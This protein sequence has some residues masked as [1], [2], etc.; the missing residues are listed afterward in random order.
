M[1]TI[2]PNYQKKATTYQKKATGMMH[3]G[4]FGGESTSE[5]F[6][7]I[8]FD[9]FI[10]TSSHY[11]SNLLVSS[12]ADISTNKEYN[13]RHLCSLFD[14]SCE[15]AITNILRRDL[16]REASF[17]VTLVDCHF[18]KW[19][20]NWHSHP[21]GYDIFMSPELLSPT[22]KGFASVNEE[23]L[24]LALHAA[25]RGLYDIDL[26]T[27][28]VFITSEYA[29]MLGYE[30]F[31]FVE[32]RDAWV[33]RLH[34]DD[35]ASTKKA[36][37]EY[38]SGKRASYNVEFRQKRK[39]GTYIWIESTAK[40]VGFSPEGRPT[41]LIGMHSDIHE[42]KIAQLQ[43]AESERLLSSFI[44][45]VPVALFRGEVGGNW[46]Y[47]S[48]RWGEFTGRSIADA[49]DF[50]W[51][52]AIHHEDKDAL[53]LQWIRWA[54][55]LGDSF[56]QAEARF[57]TPLHNER[58]FLIQAFREVDTANQLN[59]FFGT[60]TDTTKLK[61]AEEIAKDALT[62]L[63]FHVEN[64]P[65]AVIEWDSQFSIRRW[66]RAAEKVFG[67]T[68]NEMIGKNI[69]EIDL[70]HP[71]D[72]SQVNEIYTALMEAQESHNISFNRNVRKD[73]SVAYAEWYNSAL[74]NSS[75]KLDSSLSI[76]LDVTER[77]ELEKHRQ[78]MLDRER[79][80]REEA[81]K[82]NRLKDE[83]LAVLSHELRTPLNPILGWVRLLRSGECTEGRVP[84]ALAIIEKNTL[85]QIQLI[86]DLLDMSRVLQG[87]LTLEPVPLDI[88]AILTSAIQG[89]E[90]TAEQKQI[91]VSVAPN[92]T[93]EFP[94]VYG[95]PSRILQIFNNLLSNAL[96]FT[97]A[98]GKI[99][100]SINDI[101]INKAPMV[102]IQIKDTGKGISPDFLPHIFDRFAQEDSTT[103][104]NVGGLGLGLAIVRHLVD[105]HHGKIEAISEGEGKGATFTVYLPTNQG[106][107]LE[108]AVEKSESHDQ[109]IHD[110]ILKGRKI[111]VLDDDEDSLE[112]LAFCLEY[113]GASVTAI[114][115]PYKALITFEEEADRGE[116]F[117]LVLS[118]IAMP[119]MS[120]DEV[121]QSIR[122]LPPPYN[123]TPV[124]AVTAYA[125]SHDR[126]VA[127]NNGFSAHVAKP[128]D[129]N[130]LIRAI[131]NLL[132]E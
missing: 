77:V 80:A 62:R 73:G 74:V 32:T 81:E 67:W 84:H 110:T 83:F 18:K 107:Y 124:V 50:G 19:S 11:V 8:S 21:F 53:L 130:T 6:V 113:S 15:E 75:G 104:R 114:N 34:P 126:N 108:R 41:R 132:S 35:V 76:V 111:M 123:A 7:T 4:R 70:I 40:I 88:R 68:A 2:A 30:S 119:Q 82:L 42:R 112:F 16:K 125:S 29:S 27:G 103:T 86:E 55:S 63:N 98:G 60:I 9:G 131:V 101:T 66:S 117:H 52:D 43:F 48:R 121:V 5:H 3:D 64:S 72:L 20:C 36:L 12:Q 115:S 61:E 17:T 97:P 100:A 23:R 85:L 59:G 58:W 37:E 51:T 91:R 1:S 54:S 109:L 14:P 47:V 24:R 10:V 13:P 90:L 96:K 106:N 65:A 56:F 45:A 79:S 93:T 89:V 92:K 87:K 28:E 25:N 38:L 94:L 120:G 33:E 49:M 22:A 116:A 99:D 95:E 46:T 128:V 78:Q 105:L 31:E 102:C 127:I 39:N 57:L 129:P 122:A 26:V 69:L 44:E 71:E 118:D